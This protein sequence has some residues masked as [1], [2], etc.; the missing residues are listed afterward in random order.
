MNRLIIIGNGFDLAHG[1][2]SRFSDFLADYFCNA[3]EVFNN[4]GEYLD[5]YLHIKPKYPTE[6]FIR[7]KEIVDVSTSLKYFS[8]MMNDNSLEVHLDSTML[9]VGKK[10]VEKFNWVDFENLYYELLIQKYTDLKPGRD[11]Q[12]FDF[13]RYAEE[14]DRVNKELVFI[15]D[16]FLEYLK[17]ESSGKNKGH[18]KYFALMQER[19]FEDDFLLERGNPI[20][21]PLKTMLLTFN[22]TPLSGLYA[23]GMT[24]SVGFDK[25]DIVYIHGNLDNG[26][27]EPIFGYG[28]EKDERFDTLQKGKVNQV[29]EH[30]KSYRYLQNP[31]YYNLMRFLNETEFQIHIYGHSCGLS[32]GTLLSQIFEHK[33][34]RSIKVFYHERKDGSNDYR[35][36]SYEISKHFSNKQLF[37]NLVV[38]ETQCSAFPQVILQNR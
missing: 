12:F 19:F 4:T 5:D 37:R 3:I 6:I 13:S 33:N 9:Y 14:I 24:K 25:T 31:N 35:E 7:E 2:N 17:K 28:D 29:F 8:E 36:K 27:G 23:N 20:E 18:D 1:I 21:K 34:C 11:T 38:P 10:Q 16:K 22:Y 32:D 15:R 26:H 30:I